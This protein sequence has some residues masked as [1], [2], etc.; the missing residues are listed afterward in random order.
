MLVKII[1]DHSGVRIA[2]QVHHNAHTVAVGFIADVGNIFKLLLAH[3]LGD[4]FNQAGFVDLVRN[5]RNNDALPVVLTGFDIRFCPNNDSSPSGRVRFP[6]SVVA[7][8]DSP[9]GEVGSFDDLHQFL[10]IDIGVFNVGNTPVDHFAEIVRRN[11][12]RHADGDT[13]RA[14][15]EKVGDLCGENG[16]FFQCIVKIRCELNGVFLQIA[17]HF[18]RDTGEAHF[19]VPHCR[20][21]IAVDRTKISL[22]VH[23]HVAHRKILRHADDGVVYR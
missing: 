7:I 1:E 4:L 10:V 3:Q 2:L 23:K 12:C 11:I 16:G 15:D 5:L 9:G 19:S 20:R 8:D 14:V 13:A 6:H 22:S 21:R 18:F 17:Q